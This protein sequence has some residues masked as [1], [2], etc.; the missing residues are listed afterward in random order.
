MSAAVRA[1][2]RLDVADALRS[3]WVATS[4]A[5]YAAVFGLFIWLGLRESAVLG[6]TGLSRVVLNLSSAIVLVLPLVALIATSQTVV[7]ARRSGHFELFLT[8]PCRR[9]QWFGA[10]VLSRVAIVLS[11]L[12]LLLVATVVVGRMTGELGIELLVLRA[13]AVTGALAFAYVGLGFAVSVY[14]PNPERATVYALLLWLVGSALHDF[15]LIGVLLAFRLEPALV[16]ALAALN[17]MEAARL[18]ILAGVDPE[19]SVFGPVGFWLAN[20][21]GPMLTT[22]LGVGWPLLV[23]GSALALTRRR[24]NRMDLVA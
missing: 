18:G 1:L 7:G 12:L 22:V 15:A 3:R 17:P 4:A 16:F 11:P 6:F 2:L 21:L 23:G 19:L 5:T 14:A 10:V 13:A 20:T 8:Q 24:L 9:T